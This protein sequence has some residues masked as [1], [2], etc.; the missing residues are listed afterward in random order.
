MVLVIFASPAR[1][2]QYKVEIEVFGDYTFS[3]G[4]PVNLEIFEGLGVDQITPVSGGSYG[5][6]VG[7]YA[8]E[9][10]QFGFQFAQQF[11]ELELRAG[12]AIGKRSVTDMTVNN[13]HGVFTYNWGFQDD[14]VRPFMFGGLGATQYS[15][16]DVM[17]FSIDSKTRFSTTWGGG[18]KFY[19]SDN[20]GI[21]VTARWTPTYINSSPGGIYC[22]PYWGFGCYQLSNSN[23]SN[24]FALG[25]G[26]NFRF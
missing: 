9:H 7:V 19:A 11:S 14:A 12:S 3:E 8:S 22:S 10:T 6:R 13:Y 18:V 21:N 2:Q 16:S 23:F 1:A 26:I 5:V 24:Q 17:S 15:P 4:V 25:G 20:V